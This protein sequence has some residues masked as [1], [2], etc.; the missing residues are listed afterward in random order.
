MSGEA[1]YGVPG[2]TRTR[3]DRFRKPVLYPAE[4]RGQIPARLLEVLGPDC[5]LFSGQSD[6]GGLATDN[7]DEH[8]LV[9]GLNLP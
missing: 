4:L 9:V 3:D 2:V 8:G 5:S 6:Q 7:T 1:K